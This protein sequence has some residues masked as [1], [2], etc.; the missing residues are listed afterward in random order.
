MP[1]VARRKFPTV[2]GSTGETH[3]RAKEAPNI[4]TA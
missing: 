1:A 3:V 2:G 4:K